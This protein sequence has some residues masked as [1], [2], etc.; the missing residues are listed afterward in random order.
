M[1]L[2]LWGQQCLQVATCNSPERVRQTGYIIEIHRVLMWDNNHPLHHP[3]YSAS[4]QSKARRYIGQ[5]YKMM[6][7]VQDVYRKHFNNSRL[8]LFS[9]RNEPSATADH[10]PEQVIRIIYFG[11]N[12]TGIVQREQHLPFGYVTSDD[13]LSTE[14]VLPERRLSL[15]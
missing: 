14:L 1:L 5:Q 4:A 9:G 8:R 2:F 3:G 13:T 7:G 11:Q 15:E 12:Q 10:L 6:L